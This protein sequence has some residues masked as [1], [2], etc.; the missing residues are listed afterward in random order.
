MR[1]LTPVSGNP[2]A[3][4]DCYYQGLVRA[5]ADVRAYDIGEAP[6]SL[7]GRLMRRVRRFAGSEAAQKLEAAVAAA[8]P[9]VLIVFK[10]VDYPP[11]LLRKIAAQGIKM[12]NYSPDHPFRFFLAGAGNANVRDSI[13]VYD[14]YLTF[15]G[16]IAQEMAEAYPD[17]KVGVIA[18]GHAVDDA[19]YEEIATEP[20]VLR[21][22][23]NANPDEDRAAAVRLLTE[24]GVAMDL[25]GWGWEKFVSP[26]PMLG[27]YP[28]EQG[29]DMLRILRRYRF[30]LNM[31][32]PHNEGSHNLRS[33]EVPAVGGILL[34]P[35]SPEHRSFFA[36]DRDALY[37]SSPAEM[38]AQ[39]QKLL[40][41][42]AVEAGVV[43]SAARRRV[44]EIGSHFDDR[45]RAMLAAIEDRVTV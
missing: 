37:F 28:V 36:A 1:I 24:N 8:R 31:F 4:P 17:T 30:Q 38:L 21:G 40:A 15:S 14:L 43:R 44:V 35:D 5:G 2:W 45:A 26:G 29:V 12:V 25:F 19:L 27:I 39:A 41:M 7:F 16:P 23:F 3:V 33:F 10:G 9:D 22:C 6:V 13:S 32:R 20:E 18:F 42:P 34:A 11:S